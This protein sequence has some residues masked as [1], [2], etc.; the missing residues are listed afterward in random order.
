[1][2]FEILQEI[3][4]PF[5]TDIIFVMLTRLSTYKTECHMTE[6]GCIN[7]MMLDKFDHQYMHAC[8]IQFK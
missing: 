2:L 3:P 6:L 1:M 7:I 5:V 4:I 8:S